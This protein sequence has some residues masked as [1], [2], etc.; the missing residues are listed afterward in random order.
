MGAFCCVILCLDLLW[1]VLANAMY[2][3]AFFFCQNM[4]L[5][6]VDSKT[7]LQ[8]QPEYKLQNMWEAWYTF[9]DRVANCLTCVSWQWIYLCYTLHS[10]KWFCWS[11]TFAQVTRSPI[12]LWQSSERTHCLG[13]THCMICVGR[14]LALLEL[15][16]WQDGL[17]QFIRYNAISV[18]GLWISN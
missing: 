17:S 16:L 12:I 2:W 8:Q 6:S 14:K 5:H 10:E 13:Y 7:E 3:N 9:L 4:R 15:A 11:F 18:L 1:Y